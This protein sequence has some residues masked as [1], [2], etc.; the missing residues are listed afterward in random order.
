MQIIVNSRPCDVAGRT[1]ATALAELGFT[2]PAIATAL[3]GAFVPKGARDGTALR[4]G[5][6]IEVLSPMQGG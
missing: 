5:D 1:L 2:S 6:R 4:D 3:N